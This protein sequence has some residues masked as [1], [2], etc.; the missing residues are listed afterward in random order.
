MGGQGV[1]APGTRSHRLRGQT[2]EPHDRGAILVAAIFDAF[3]AIYERRTADLLRL[4]TSGSGVLGPGAIHPDL[5]DRL[6]R[7]ASKAAQHVLTMCVRALDYCPP[8]D[9][10]FGEY[11]RAIITA[12][13]DLVEDDR[14]KYRVAFVEAF[15]RRGIYPPDVR[16]MSVDS[17][18][19]R[20]PGERRDG[21]LPANWGRCSSNCVAKS[22]SMFSRSRTATKANAKRSSICSAPSAK[23]CITG[24]TRTS[25]RADRGDAE[26]MGLDPG[27]KF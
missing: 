16:T 14:L 15:R 12:D 24:W 3:L 10:T 26:Y 21:I 27:P 22:C 6:A 13:C 11:L 25:K 5:V 7:E 20:T 17:L 23:N 18:V 8:V 9:I 19:W 1:G 2:T 4:A